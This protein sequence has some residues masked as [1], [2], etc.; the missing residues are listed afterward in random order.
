MSMQHLMPHIGTIFDI[1]LFVAILGFMYKVNVVQE[2]KIE[3]VYERMDEG[4]SHATSLYVSEKVCDERQKRIDEKL[5]RV[6]ADTKEMKKDIKT[7][8]QRHERPSTRD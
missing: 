8:L 6:E 7:L 4:K 5:D 1:G 3:R 2:K